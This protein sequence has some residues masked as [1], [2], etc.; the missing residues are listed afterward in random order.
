MVRDRAS[1]WLLELAGYSPNAA[2]GNHRGGG[3][4]AGYL[5]DLSDEQRVPGLVIVVHEKA[6]PLAADAAG[7][8]IDVTPNPSS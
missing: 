2:T 7:L 3:P 6:A 8:V 5:I 4:R 1:S